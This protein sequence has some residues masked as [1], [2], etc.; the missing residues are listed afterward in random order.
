MA[1]LVPVAGTAQAEGVNCVQ[2][3]QRASA[4]DL[5]GDAWQWWEA[6]EGQYGRGRRPHPGAVMVFSKTGHL[7]YGHVAMVRSLR[8]SR[9]ILVDHANWSPVRGR[10]GQVEK[11]VLV[12]DVSP[13]NDWS[14]VRVWYH[15]TADIGN[16]VYPV[17][18][19]VYPTVQHHL[20]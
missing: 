4:I 7:R 16:T 13:N 11:A 17:R 10:R 18:G 19:F 6:A 14:Q 5:H 2:F 1:G 15:P 20:R 9:S 3:V 12:V 8:N